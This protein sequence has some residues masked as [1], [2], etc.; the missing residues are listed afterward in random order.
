MV[1]ALV[2]AAGCRTGRPAGVRTTASG[3]SG[4]GA[5]TRFLW[6][7]EGR[8][9]FF[10]RDRE[11]FDNLGYGRLRIAVRDDEVRVADDSFAS[12]II[13]SARAAHGWVFIAADGTS[14]RADTFVGP[15]SMLGHRP[16]AHGPRDSYTANQQ[17][18]RLAITDCNGGAWISDGRAFERVAGLDGE[19]VAEILF[20]DERHGAAI[21]R[22]GVLRCTRDGGARWETVPTGGAGARE[23]YIE[24][25]GLGVLADDRRSLTRD[26]RLLDDERQSPDEGAGPPRSLEE[27]TGHYEQDATLP[28]LLVHHDPAWIDALHGLSFT[29]GTVVVPS[30]MG[31]RILDA[32]TA[33]ELREVADESQRGYGGGQCQLD[34]V[35][36]LLR[37]S[38]YWMPACSPHGP[39]FDRGGSSSGYVDLRGDRGRRISDEGYGPAFHRSLATDDPDLA[40]APGRCDAAPPAN[41]EH[42]AP[43]RVD[44]LCE[45]TRDATAGRDRPL[46]EPIARLFGV[47]GRRALVAL[48]D[49]SLGTVDLSGPTTAS[50]PVTRILGAS[51]GQVVAAGL[52]AGGVVT[53]AVREGVA[54]RSAAVGRLGASMEAV[55]LPP[56]VDRVVFADPTHGFAWSS[57]LAP[58]FRT[59]DRGAHWEEL[60]A[61]FVGPDGNAVP[62][63]TGRAW[64][65]E[66]WAPDAR[67]CTLAHCRL[68]E[69]LVVAGWGPVRE[70]SGRLFMTPEEPPAAP[71]SGAETE[72]EPEAEPESA[73]EPAATASWLAPE[74]LPRLRCELGP[75]RN[76]P[77]LAP[78]AHPA[79]RPFRTFTGRALDG[80]VH[81]VAWS[82][83][84]NFHARFAWHGR[85]AAGPY[86][87]VGTEVRIPG[88]VGG[89]GRPENLP[90]LAMRV[91]AVGRSRAVVFV[92]QTQTV[93]WQLLS[94]PAG[95]EAFPVEA[96]GTIT[97]DPMLQRGGDGFASLVY[98]GDMHFGD[99]FSMSASA[100]V[101]ESRRYQYPR[102]LVALAERGSERGI[103]LLLP[104]A[105]PSFRVQPLDPDAR[106]LTPAPWRVEGPLQPCTT[107]HAAEAWSLSLPVRL[108]LEGLDGATGLSTWVTLD[109]N[110]EG[111]CLRSVEALGADGAMSVTTASDGSLRG[112]VT[113]GESFSTV[114]CVIP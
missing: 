86:A 95:G 62:R 37:E 3:A 102:S 21:T 40:V 9:R 114:R 51:P 17:R 57:S 6:L 113:R 96:A 74:Q 80:D 56:G 39:C 22:D 64:D 15:L 88:S 42:Q 58:I 109:P 14:A 97:F 16:C 104:G 75:S 107:E 69:Q 27:L 33:R 79:R 108:T 78:L 71:E 18:G 112:T 44:A 103:A 73:P 4:S 5:P 110:A 36:Y 8:A 111:V 13:V 24:H 25:Y 2:V 59:R 81:A 65:D 19:S 84:D 46:A 70:R 100:S 50:T 82:E 77:A 106:A 49:G 90:R 11:G 87:A 32:S 66:R 63:S 34:A 92:H 91:L 89:E 61:L 94:V 47:V 45:F 35:G 12:E 52:G 30:T 67:H 93:Y 83:G 68:H 1:A 31:A 98:A 55:P 26:C 20:V 48:V 38:C 41:G 101:L 23:L 29:D 53:A 54:L 76:L 7:P 72:S 10:G 43:D 105:S 60:P 85:D 99:A 28:R